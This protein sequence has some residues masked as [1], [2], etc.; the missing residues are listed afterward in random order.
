MWKQFIERFAEWAADGRLGRVRGVLAGVFLGFIYL[1]WGFWD[2][3]AFGLI[4]VI[5]YWFGLKSDIREKWF[6]IQAV[7]RWLSDRWYR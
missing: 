1:I 6:D 7:F 2:M 3:L 5:G 4:V